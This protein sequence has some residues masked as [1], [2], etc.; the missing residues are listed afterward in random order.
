MKQ[1]ADGHISLHVPNIIAIC[2]NQKA[3]D[4]IAG[5]LYHCYDTKPWTFSSLVQ[6]LEQIEELYNRI[7][8]PQA[9]Q[10]A[11]SLVEMSPQKK[12]PLIKVTEPDAIA[13]KRGKLGTFLL[14]VKCRQNSSWQGEL[15]WIEGAQKLQFSSELEFIKLVHNRLSESC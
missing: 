1:K 8:F 3:D 13:E 6:M 15:E 9:S 5:E 7:S 12:E 4:E 14:Y 2:V 10:R 11:R